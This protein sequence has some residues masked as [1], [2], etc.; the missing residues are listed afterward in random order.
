MKYHMQFSNNQNP[1]SEIK[2]DRITLATPDINK[3]SLILDAV[4]ASTED[5]YPWLPWAKRDIT[6]KDIENYM[7]HFIECNKKENPSNLFFDIW[8]NKTKK[9]LGNIYFGQI[10]WRAPTFSIGYWLDSRECKKGYMTEAVNALSHVAFKHF[11][12]NRVEISTS[13][14]NVSANRIPEKLNFELE[15]EFINHHINYATKEV[16]NTMVYSCVDTNRLPELKQLVWTTASQLES[17]DTIISW[18]KKVL[19]PSTFESELIVETS[20]SSVVKINAG[21][22]PVYLKQT[23]RDLFL[24]AE[25]IKLLCAGGIKAIPQ[26][27]ADNKNEHCFLMKKC[28][29]VTLRDY[30]DGNLQLDILKQ[31]IVSYKNLQQSTVKCV[32]KLLAIGVPDWRLDKFPGLYNELIRNT[33][34]LDDNN[35]TIEQQRQLHQYKDRVKNLCAELATFR[36]AETLNHSDFHDNNILYDN[37]N[38][39]T[40]IIDLGETAINHPL[41]SLHACIEAVKNRYHLTEDS[42]EYKLLQQCAFDGFLDD[43]QK[44]DRAIEIITQLFPVYLL[45][46]QKRFLDAIHMPFDA[47]DPLSVKQH[48]KIN[49]GFVWFIKNMEATN[50]Q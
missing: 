9:Y 12:A 5:I 21:A 15:A 13:K 39:T 31:A 19:N 16:S 1:I 42:A 29:D 17:H 40:A 33:E 36:I 14:E 41:F 22:E 24:E 27:I 43:K 8:D 20:W 34:Y 32:D 11:K 28:G 4:K 3:A 49:K 45:F 35:V 50:A 38:K 2:T 10:E 26:I 48:D 44:F 18:A 7:N 23:P 6:L 37:T 30:F 46:T 47:N 25:I